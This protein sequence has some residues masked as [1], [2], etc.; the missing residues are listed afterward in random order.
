[1]DLETPSETH[2]MSTSGMVTEIPHARPTHTPISTGEGTDV[3]RQEEPS[4]GGT[5]EQMAAPVLPQED[6]NPEEQLM[7]GHQY[8]DKCP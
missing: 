4:P 8:L 1:M 5:I 2:S 7:T 6:I 3:E